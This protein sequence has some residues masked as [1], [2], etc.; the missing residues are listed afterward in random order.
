MKP[1][2]H[3][4]RALHLTYACLLGGLISA[5]NCLAESKLEFEMQSGTG[6]MKIEAVSDEPPGFWLLQH[7]TDFSSWRDLAFLEN[8]GPG[9][10]RPGMD[11]PTRALPQPAANRGFFRAIHSEQD[12]PRLRELLANQI[13][14]RLRTFE[15]YQFEI[16]YSSGMFFWRGIISVVDHQVVLRETLS[17]GPVG[18]NGDWIPSIDG[19]IDRLAPALGEKPAGYNVTWNVLGYPGTASVDPSAEIADEEIGWTIHSVTP[20]TDPRVSELL[21]QQGKRR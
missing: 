14:W 8:P 3:C 1:P 21:A 11:L 13:T 18:G 7:S 17:T 6:M 16:S 20:V 12:Q 5:G 15:D 10:L 2:L 9:R 19:L 4:R